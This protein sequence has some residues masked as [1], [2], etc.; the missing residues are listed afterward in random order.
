MTTAFISYPPGAGGNHL[1]NILAL[2]SDFLPDNP[3][4]QN[5]QD[6]YSPGGHIFVH[7]ADL[8]Q[9]QLRGNMNSFKLH[10][11]VMAPSKNHLLFGHFAEIAS[12][13]KDIKLIKDKKFILLG[14]DSQ[15]CL[16]LWVKRSE[17]LK[18][19]AGHCYFQGEQFFLYES[20]MYCDLFKTKESNVMNV[21]ISEWFSADIQ[22]PLERIARFLSCNIDY[23]ECKL[24][25]E[26]WW[27]K[28]QKVLF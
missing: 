1:R 5:M 24:L 10:Q 11:A 3:Y 25:H 14:M 28:N 27:T 6:Q 4:K 22:A 2:A 18:I 17:H 13:R 19:G 26:V 23:D 12:F 7:G 20:Y 8:A 21:S 16:D 9:A 15:Q